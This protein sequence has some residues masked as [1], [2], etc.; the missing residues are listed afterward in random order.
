MRYKSFAFRQGESRLALFLKSTLWGILL[1]G[2][3]WAKQKAKRNP[4]K[5][6]NTN[7][8][9]ILH[10]TLISLFYDNNPSVITYRFAVMYQPLLFNL[11]YKEVMFLDK[12]KRIKKKNT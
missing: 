10:A 5:A 9:Q 6:L 3:P 11:P 2:L 7:K 12:N 1:D 4:K 8:Y